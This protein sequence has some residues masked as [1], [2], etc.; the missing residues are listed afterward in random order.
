MPNR[1]KIK[2]TLYNNII[3]S[4]IKKME[5]YPE[6]GMQRKRFMLCDWLH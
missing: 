5:N 6:V 4:K 3:Y 2:K 1:V